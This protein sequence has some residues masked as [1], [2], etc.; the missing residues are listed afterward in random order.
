MGASEAGPVAGFKAGR[1]DCVWLG[2]L[3]PGTERQ[4]SSWM[5]IGGLGSGHS[6]E[7]SHGA[8]PREALWTKSPLCPALA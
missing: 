4:D 6:W 2:E 3:G 1:W 7:S 5:L 8:K